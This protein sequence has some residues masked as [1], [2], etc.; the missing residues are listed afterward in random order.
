M[1]PI[2]FAYERPLVATQDKTLKTKA[3][4]EAVMFV[5]VTREQRK[6]PI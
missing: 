6:L 5:L 2:S 1:V 4:G 3:L